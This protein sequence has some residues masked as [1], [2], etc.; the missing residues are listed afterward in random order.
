MSADPISEESHRQNNPVTLTRF[1][2]AERQQYKD[3]TGNFAML[4]Q[5][6]QLACKVISNYTRKG[7]IGNIFGAAGTENS[8]GDAQ[9]K[10]DIIANEV[11]INS[12]SFSQQ[13]YVLCSEE[14]DE[15]IILDTTSGGYAVVFDPLDGSSNIDCNL[16]VGTIFGIYK[17]DAKS[18]EKTSAKSILKPGRELIAAG[19]AVYDAATM[20]VLTTGNKPILLPIDEIIH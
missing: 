19:Y 4:L 5:S 16:S 17:K 10:L 15:P 8:T 11:M 20:I 9:K 2:M 14:N 6:I 1:L 12:I 7:G 13:A 18:E 3:S